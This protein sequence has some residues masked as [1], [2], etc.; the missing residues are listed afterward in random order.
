MTTPILE[1]RQIH[2]SFGQVRALQGADI[3]IHA[4]EVVAL[5]GDNGA[6]KSTLAKI[7][8]GVLTADSGTILVDGTPTQIRS[9]LDARRHGIE[10][11][12]QDLSLAL[13]L[14]AI[15]N[16]FLGR[17][18]PAPGLFGRLGFMNR[19][20]MLKAG[21]EA[22]ASL[23][24]RVPEFTAP[25]ANF[26]GGERQ[27]VAVARAVMWAKRLIFMDEPTAALGV[28]QT[29]N[30]LNLIRR[31]RDQGISVCLI[32]HSM[33]DVLAVSD[34]IVV[35]RRG[36]CVVTYDARTV[37]IDELVGAMTGSLELEGAR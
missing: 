9:P 29:R 15:Q 26:S 18:I 28:K 31:V 14:T 30:V 36:R 21:A 10:T 20:A 8:S 34:R 4:G 16:V 6:G 24:V 27:G 19:A 22:F 13:D 25:V 1:A 37:T 11:V 32:S 5:I 7:L 2:K 17:E 12:Y 33:P 23:G 3:S 35:L